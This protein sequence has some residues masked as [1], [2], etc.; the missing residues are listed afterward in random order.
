MHNDRGTQGTDALLR[1]SS[2]QNYGSTSNFSSRSSLYNEYVSSPPCCPQFCVVSH[3]RRT[4]CLIVT[5]DV[6]LSFLLWSIFVK[7]KDGHFLEEM[8]KEFTHYTFET[9]LMDYLLFAAFRFLTLIFSYG[10]F[11]LRNPYIVA[12][13]TL[14]T[15]IYILPKIV[16]FKPT[17]YFSYILLG[18]SFVI[19]WV[20]TW[21]LDFK[22]LPVESSH[23]GRIF[24]EEGIIGFPGRKP[25]NTAE[26][27]GFMTPSEGS[28]EEE[29]A[30]SDPKDSE[31]FRKAKEAWKLASLLIDNDRGWKKETEVDG[32][33]V[34][35]QQIRGLGKILR[36]EAE[37]K[38]TASSVFRETTILCEKMP[39][40]NKCVAESKVIKAI[41]DS[42]DI[43]YHVTKETGN[44]L[45]SSRDF[46]SVRHW[47]QM[48]NNNCMLS[49]ATSVNFP[50][51]VSKKTHIRGDTKLTA[52]MYENLRN[53]NCRL[54]M[55]I[56]ID[57]KG[58]I[59]QKVIDSSLSSVVID[60]V[61]Y[62]QAYMNTL[63]EL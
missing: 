15:C 34:H 8:L 52:W 18:E 42:S 50:W 55:L 32:I 22:V 51:M 29:D 28:D 20:E 43:M 58:W 44:G 4:F 63:S 33:A 1:S 5:F 12:I 38:A 7:L 60:T 26:G 17:G 24:D 25:I 11:K 62:L 30:T 23:G 19:A 14:F 40:W 6:L 9:S 45:I 37:I 35:S 59:P 46:V 39:Q 56:A 2:S 10:L 3:V 27:D 21:F 57:V 48:K 36:G 41:N 54:K 16:L 61:R 13:T 49:V 47:N 53:N 31:Y